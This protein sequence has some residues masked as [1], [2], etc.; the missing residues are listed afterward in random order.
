MGFD[1]LLLTQKKKCVTAP[2]LLM[3]L[4]IG[5]ETLQ[6]Y[7]RNIF[8]FL[9]DTRRQLLNS[10]WSPLSDSPLHDAPYIFKKR[11]STKFVVDWASSTLVP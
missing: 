11:Q 10:P 9:L 6:F 2:L 7:K 3:T 1:H 4:F 5:L 8:S